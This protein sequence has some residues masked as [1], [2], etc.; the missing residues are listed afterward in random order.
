MFEAEN[1]RVYGVSYDSEEQL[2]T[3]ADGHDVTYDLL[4]DPDS[5][6]IRKF[7]IL[8]TLITPDDPEQGAGRSYYGL[9]F[10]GVYVTDATGVV[11]EKFFHRYYGTRDSAGAIRDSALG[12]LLARHEAPTAELNGAQVNL[13]A[14][15]SDA[16]LKF[17]TQ[18]TIYV[19]FELDGGLH[20]Y[21][22]P[23]PDGY[24]ASEVTIQD[25]PGLRIGVPQYPATHARA[26][27]ELGVT[28]NVYEGV[29][30]VAIPVTPNA[31]VFHRTNADRPEMVNL[32]VSVLYQVCSETV[33][34]VPRTEELSLEVP[35]EPLLA[36]DAR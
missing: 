9:P 28:L 3:F 12:E 31:E 15:L 4:S 32:P 24:I 21:G 6:V 16:S 36:R 8:N 29:V 13:S 25:M 27:P 11:T 1:I 2:R 5:A 7:G 14:F 18:S 20:V 10:P 35:F 17:E 19:R 26:F 30:D 33:C 23:L 22:R 34:Y